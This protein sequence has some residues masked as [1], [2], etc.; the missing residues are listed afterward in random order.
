[1]AWVALG[2]GLGAVVAVQTPCSTCAECQGASDVIINASKVDRRAFVGCTALYAVEVPGTVVFIEDAAFEQCSSL[3]TV[4]MH[5][6]MT[7]IGKDSF[8]GCS[9]L[10][11]VEIPW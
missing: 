9:S 7:A 3:T 6:G 8:S 1:M 5:A 2:L 10:V 4:V 11:N